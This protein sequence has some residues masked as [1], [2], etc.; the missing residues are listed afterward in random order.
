MP[1]SGSTQLP[2]ASNPAIGNGTLPGGV[3]AVGLPNS[4]NIGVSPGA[5]SG[6]PTS[7]APTFGGAATFGG[8]PALGA[9]ASASPTAP[10]AYKGAT[11][12]GGFSPGTTGRSTGYDFGAGPAGD[13]A[14]RSASTT[15]PPNTANTGNPLLR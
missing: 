2:T 9:G 15:L 14:G 8:A 13:Q 1:V 10:T 3:G 5:A 6:L 7:A 11:A 12:L 4:S